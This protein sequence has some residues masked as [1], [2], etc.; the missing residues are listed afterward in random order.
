MINNQIATPPYVGIY[1]NVVNMQTVNSLMFK[2]NTLS[3]LTTQADGTIG[4][5][6]TW[7]V[8][9]RGLIGTPQAP[10]TQVP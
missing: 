3:S 6:V 10:L 5:R 4:I 8:Y 9:G 1:Q 7:T 2:F